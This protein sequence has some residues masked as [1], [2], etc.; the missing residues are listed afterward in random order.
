MS[1]WAFCSAEPR[2]EHKD[3]PRPFPQRIRI[4]LCL[5]SESLQDL[6]VTVS[7]RRALYLIPVASSGRITDYPNAAA[8]T[9][10]WRR[11]HLRSPLCHMHPTQGEARPNQLWWRSTLTSRL[12]KWRIVCVC[13]FYGNVFIHVFMSG[14]RNVCRRE[15]ALII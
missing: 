13:V 12:N 8:R 10:I 5:S 11:A 4:I 6:R 2:C 3:S 7:Q 9:H 14:C 1:N 15:R